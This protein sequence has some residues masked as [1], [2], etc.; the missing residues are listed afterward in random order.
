M[1]LIDQ[2]E[3]GFNSRDYIKSKVIGYG[4]AFLTAGISSIMSSTKI[5][6][7][8]QS[9]CQKLAS[10]LRNAKRF[11]SICNWTANKL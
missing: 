9:C 5:L 1:A 8:A 4:I 7:K 6:K 2:G 11:I 3:S 10:K